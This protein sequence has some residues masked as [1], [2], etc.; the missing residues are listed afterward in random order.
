MSKIIKEGRDAVMCFVFFKKLFQYFSSKKA[1][2]RLQS[3][4]FDKNTKGVYAIQISIDF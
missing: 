1:V 2:L 4:F 3:G